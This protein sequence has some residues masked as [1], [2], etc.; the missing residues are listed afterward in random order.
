MPWESNVQP[1]ARATPS[2]LRAVVFDFDG[3]LVDSYAAI[4]ASVNHVRATHDLPPLPEAEVRKHVGRGPANL[5]E[6]TVPA[7]DAEKDLAEYKAHHPSVLKS[8]T[9]LLPGVTQTLPILH[10]HGLRLAV[11]SNKLRGFTL[12]L[13]DI[14]G[15]SKL[16]QAVIGP[17][18]APR[19]KPAPDMLLAA[20]HRLGVTRT[21][22]LYVG[23]MVV[24]IETARS[25][26]VRVWV[27]TT[28]S[29]DVRT[30]RAARP[31]RIVRDFCELQT[32][33]TGAHDQT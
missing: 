20:L 19:I 2:Q 24:D 29:D 13:L 1:D 6:H 3:T 30:L 8:G 14:F 5:L 7:G 17:E 25:A 10:A 15:L 27:V 12:E 31:D 18:D 22:A 26:G 4:T 9:R 32:L 28:G 16:F 33:S 11:C 23:D 21:E